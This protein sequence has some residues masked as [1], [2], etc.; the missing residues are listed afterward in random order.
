MSYKHEVT[1]RYLGLDNVLDAA[2]AE[3]DRLRLALA[4]AE[5]RVASIALDRDK[6][7]ES[8]EVRGRLLSQ[9]Q[10]EAEKAKAQ[11]VDAAVNGAGGLY[12][13]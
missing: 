12:L 1:A 7:M 6:W 3:V 5:S 4:A 10:D 8:A 13:E 11:N 9:A 2:C